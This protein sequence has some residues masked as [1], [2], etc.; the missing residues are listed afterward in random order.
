MTKNSLKAVLDVLRSRRRPTP[1]DGHIRAERR[2]D[3]W[4]GS[5]LADLGPRNREA[6]IDI[7]AAKTNN[8]PSNT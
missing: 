4:Y 8:E 5:A 2:E 6:Q 7:H 3:A 1:R